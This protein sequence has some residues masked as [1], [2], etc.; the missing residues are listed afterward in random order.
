MAV[1]SAKPYTLANSRFS[2][3]EI[4]RKNDARQR[5][6]LGPSWAPSVSLQLLIEVLPRAAKVVIYFCVFPVAT[7]NVN[8]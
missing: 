6:Q 4:V 5:R 2:L 3:W 7:R 8:T 1:R